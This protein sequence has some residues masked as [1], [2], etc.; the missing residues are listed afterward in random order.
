M[1]QTGVLGSLSPANR[2]RRAAACWS[3]PPRGSSGRPGGAC[4]AAVPTASRPSAIKPRS[5]TSGPLC[6]THWLSLSSPRPGGSISQADHPPLPEM[7]SSLVSSRPLALLAAPQTSLSHPDLGTR[8]GPGPVRV[9]LSAFAALPGHPLVRFQRCRRYCFRLHRNGPL[10]DGGVTDG[11]VVPT[12]AP[13][14][15][16]PRPQ[17]RL[18]SCRPGCRRALASPRGFRRPLTLRSP[19]PSRWPSCPTYYF[20]DGKPSLPGAQAQTRESSRGSS[21]PLAPGAP[22]NGRFCGSA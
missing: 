6:S 11:R 9:F 21:L 18:P 16:H 12:T 3:E 22:P 15:V 4:R 19:E 5:G 14:N 17:T 1:Q 20:R 13:P 8:E 10:P 7:P 2:R